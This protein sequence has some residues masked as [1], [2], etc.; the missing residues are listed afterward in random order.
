MNP[1]RISY[2]IILLLWISVL[3]VATI[4]LCADLPIMVIVGLLGWLIVHRLFKIPARP[5]RKRS[6]MPPD[7]GTVAQKLDAIEAEM[8]RIGYWQD[9]PLKPEQYDFRAAFAGDT[10]AFPQW[11]Q[12]IFVPN[13]RAIIAQRGTFPASSQVGTYA[14]REF[15]T[16]GGDVGGLTDLLIEFDNLF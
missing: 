12:F 15:D 5:A 7:Y 1:R 11:L 3:A 6:K 13:V 16:Y 4:G 8:K 2:A 10:M 14:V 9:A